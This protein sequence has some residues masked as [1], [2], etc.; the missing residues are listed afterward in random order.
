MEGV[1]EVQYFSVNYIKKKQEIDHEMH[2][3]HITHPEEHAGNL[4]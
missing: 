4:G 1:R 2:L 3:L